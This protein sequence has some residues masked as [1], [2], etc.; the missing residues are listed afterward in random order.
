VVGLI[1]DTTYVST[2]YIFT[3]FFCSFVIRC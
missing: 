1:R 3:H 2:L